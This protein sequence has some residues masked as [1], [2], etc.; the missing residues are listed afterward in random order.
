[1]RGYWSAG[2]FLAA[3]VALAPFCVAQQ[4]SLIDVDIT[5]QTR[6]AGSL[7]FQEL[8]DGSVMR[9]GDALKIMF[10]TH[11]NCY[12]Y[13]FQT[14]SSGEPYALFPMERFRGKQVGN[15]NPVQA[16]VR[17]YVPGQSTSFELDDV[18][19]ME[20]IYFLA[21]RVKDP[22]LEAAY[23]ALEAKQRNE[24]V[25]QQHLIMLDR[26]LE[27]AREA[28]GMI[29]IVTD[30]NAGSFIW[31]EGGRT[32]TA[33]MQRLTGLCDGCGHVLHFTHK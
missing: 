11:E 22:D 1:M 5:Y 23:Q 2:L 33:L 30:P 7:D 28:K 19:G 32:H 10:K 14:D 31:D 27:E 21:Y 29:K 20:T 18:T 26:I 12:V 13:I 17:Y 8:R 4:A 6:Q 25:T 24:I 3:F 15:S 9:S 16:G